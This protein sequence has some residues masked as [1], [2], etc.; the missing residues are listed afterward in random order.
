MLIAGY[1]MGFHMSRESIY[2]EGD[3]SAKYYTTGLDFESSLNNIFTETSVKSMF[4][5]IRGLIGFEISNSLAL[6]AGISLEGHVPGVTVK[7]ELF[8]SG[9]PHTLQHT[10]IPY[11]LEL[12][13]RWFVGIRI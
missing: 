13:P 11:T 1:G 4:P 10:E 2:V 7:N 8:H 5:S 6:F 12:Y 3:L 9:D